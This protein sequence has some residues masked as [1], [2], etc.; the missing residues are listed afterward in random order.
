MDSELVKLRIPNIIYRIA[1]TLEILVSFLVI[2]AILL[3]IWALALEVGII[4][5]SPA[6]VELLHGFLATAFTVVIGI[7][8][9]KM[10]SRHNMSSCVEVLLFAI[11][12]QM[13]VE[14]TNAFEN[15]VMVISIAI[16]FAIRKWLFIP[17]LDDRKPQGKFLKSAT[18]A[19][20]EH[21]AGK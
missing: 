11:A 10:L 16:L 12:R 20:S 2:V 4:A 13:V 14:H 1:Q 8:F 7:E 18:Q 19:N 9:L 6:D 15:L 3:S 21:S 5:V 17:G